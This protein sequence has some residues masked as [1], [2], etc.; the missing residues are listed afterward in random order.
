MPYGWHSHGGFMKHFVAAALFI[1]ALSGCSFLRSQISVFHQLPLELGGTTY[2]M[3]PLKEQEGSLEH[4]A[5]EDAVRQELNVKG[6]RETTVEQAL[7]VV[8]LSLRDRY[9]QRGGVILSHHWPNGS[10][11]KFN[12]RN[13]AKLR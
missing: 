3:I 13:R 4:K 10:F 9:R 6:F 2:A 1:I 8:I 7:L 12:V 5:Y 11:I